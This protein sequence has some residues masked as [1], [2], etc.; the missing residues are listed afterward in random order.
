MSVTVQRWDDAPSW[1]EFVA[2]TPGAHF[3]QSWEWGELAPSLGGRVARLAAVRGGEICAAMQVFINPVRETDRSIL[4]VPRGPALRAPCIQFVG[5]LLDAARSV[6]QESGV[7]GIRM[8]PNAAEGDCGWDHAFRALDLHPTWPPSQPRS[9]WV[10]DIDAEPDTLLANMKQKTRYNIRLAS[11]KGV[12]VVDAGTD[13]LDTFYRLYQETAARD[14]FFIQPRSFYAEM[15]DV[16]DRAGSFSLLFALHDE[17]PIAAVTLLRFGETCWY[18]HGASSNEHRNF[19]A[20]YLLQWE[21]IRRAQEWG[22]SLYD[23]RAVPD[24]LREDQDMYGVYRFK[25]GFGGRKVTAL[26]TYTAPYRP[27]LFGTWQVFFSGRFALQERR[28]RRA[29]LPARQFA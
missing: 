5:P 27:G 23:F 3:Q 15:F 12:E 19:M 29:G 17:R 26:H 18:V 16:F 20:T 2:S 14:D 4:Y 25:E 9:S 7:I 10:L 24:V 28:R 6:G 1:N 8:E 22:C 11:K 13:Q 21:A